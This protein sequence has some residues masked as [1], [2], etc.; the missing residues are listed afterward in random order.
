MSTFCFFT[1]LKFGFKQKQER[2]PPKPHHYKS[3]NFVHVN[4]K[5]SKVIFTFFGVSLTRQ[6]R[7]GSQKTIVKKMRLQLQKYIK[8]KIYLES[9]QR[10]VIK[11]IICAI[12]VL[13]ANLKFEFPQKHEGDSMS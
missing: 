13:F 6:M 12:F 5:N 1:N 9:P 2:E 11:D 4:I 8:S 7:K 10:A 3:F